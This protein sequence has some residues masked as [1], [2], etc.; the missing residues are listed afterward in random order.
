MQRRNFE[1]VAK[2][3]RGAAKLGHVAKKLFSETRLKHKLTA[4]S[5]LYR[6]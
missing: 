1:I 2:V 4:T 5:W 3:T 6:G